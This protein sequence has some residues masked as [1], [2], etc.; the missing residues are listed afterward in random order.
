MQGRI[1]GIAPESRVARPKRRPPRRR[2]GALNSG[3]V[4]Y[5]P[6]G[7]VLAVV[8]P[9]VATDRRLVAVETERVVLVGPDNG[10]LA[11]GVA[12]LGGA[13]RVVSLTN[14]E[15]HLPAP[16]PT[17]AGRDVMAPAA[18]H[19]AA[20]VA[21]GELGEE[22]DPLGLVP[23]T[24]SLPHDD[25]SGIAGEVWWVDRFGNCQR[26]PDDLVPGCASRPSG[27]R[28]TGPP[29]S[30]PSPGRPPSWLCS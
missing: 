30:P 16:G 2:G 12:M 25:E 6:V 28:A 1:A 14:E 19:L 27:E 24:V 9:G 20:G 23:G 3:S 7:V 21:L 4:Q 10:L 17:F 18:A 26:K 15:Y 11:P 5:L 29:V 13:R 8:D 22:I